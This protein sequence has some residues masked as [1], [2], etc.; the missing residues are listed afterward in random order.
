MPLLLSFQRLFIDGFM[1][2]GR[3]GMTTDASV[4][5]IE[6]TA[7]LDVSSFRR[8]GQEL[9]R[10]LLRRSRRPQD[11]DDL[12]QEVYLRL[13]RHDS[14]KCVHKPLAYL[15]GV[16]SH[17]VA[18]Y[19]NESERE[20]ECLSSDGERECEETSSV[21]QDDLADQ[22]NLQQQLERALAQLPPTHAA[23][24]IAHKHRGLSYEEVAA[25]LDLSIHTVEKYVTQAKAQIRT[26]AWER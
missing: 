17:V 8:Y 4:P 25:E 13:L 9:H 12:A 21:A 2:D 6:P 3:C 10:Y 19:R 16:A 24:L 26:M 11:V 20:T 15:Y 1:F 14:S 22:L 5:A 23:V 7:G 18:D